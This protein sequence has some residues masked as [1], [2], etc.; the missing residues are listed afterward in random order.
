MTIDG[1]DLAL[2]GLNICCLKPNI[3]WKASIGNDQASALRAAV[4]EVTLV[5]INLEVM[6]LRQTMEVEFGYV[7]DD[8]NIKATKEKAVKII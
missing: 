2:F 4:N 3:R 6:P 1:V 5:P 8:K 7:L